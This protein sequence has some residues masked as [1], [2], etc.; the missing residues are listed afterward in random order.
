MFV[1]LTISVDD[2]TL[3]QA[4]AL[5]R[6]RGVSL[7]DLLRQMLE[8]LVGEPCANSTADELRGLLRGSAGRSDGKPITRDDPY[9]GRV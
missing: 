7:Q 6:S 3:E 8:S 4:R 9:S 2:A 5:A 1:N